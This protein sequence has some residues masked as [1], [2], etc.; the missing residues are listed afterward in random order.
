MPDVSEPINTLD[1]IALADSALAPQTNVEVTISAIAQYS[2]SFSA[3][4][5]ANQAKVEQAENGPERALFEQLDKKHR[6]VLQLS[7]VLMAKSHVDLRKLKVKGKGIM[8]YLD[9]LPDRI[10]LRGAKKG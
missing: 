4:Y 1:L 2:E 6:E 7:K 10:S 5:D 3:W 9:T 8:A